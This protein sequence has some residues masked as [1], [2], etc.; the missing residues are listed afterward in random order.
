M[1]STQGLR[2]SASMRP[3]RRRGISSSKCSEA[4]RRA[5]GRKSRTVIDDRLEARPAGF[6]LNFPDG[7]APWACGTVRGSPGGQCGGR[8]HRVEGGR[9][10]ESEPP[11]PRRCPERETCLSGRTGKSFSCLKP[12]PRFRESRSRPSE[13]RGTPET[14][15]ASRQCASKTAGCA[16]FGEF[17]R[18]PPQKLFSLRIA[19]SGHRCRSLCSGR[20]EAGRGPARRRL[21]PHRKGESG[22]SKLRERRTRACPAG[23]ARKHSGP[24]N[25]SVF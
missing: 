24:G 8:T 16:T 12:D 19:G 17:R 21:G 3:A 9:Q 22:R 11:G 6:C 13:P 5:A 15:A 10:E 1:M 14:P 7:N 20:A 23:A 2:G 18:P 25:H 4:P